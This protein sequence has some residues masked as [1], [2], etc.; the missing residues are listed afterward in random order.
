MAARQYSVHVYS[1]GRGADHLVFCTCRTYTPGQ[2]PFRH[3]SHYKGMSEPIVCMYEKDITAIVCRPC[4]LV[5]L[6]VLLL[7][8]NY[9]RVR[10][11]R[12]F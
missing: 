4:N 8:V 5:L 1:R 12:E 11:T 2:L 3:Y 10:V 7:S 9:S 6:L